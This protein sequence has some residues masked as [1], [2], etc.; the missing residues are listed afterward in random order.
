MKYKIIDSYFETNGDDLDFVATMQIDG[1]PETKEV[2]LGKNWLG[3]RNVKET[4]E[5]FA[6]RVRQAFGATQ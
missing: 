3:D 2:R 5:M 1:A 6:G 4:L